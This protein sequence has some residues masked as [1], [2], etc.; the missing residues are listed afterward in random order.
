MKQLLLFIALTS[1]HLFSYSQRN[2]RL[3]T[4][5]AF[6]TFYNEQFAPELYKDEIVAEHKIREIAT[7]T[8]SKKSSHTSNLTFD[9]DGRL[10]QTETKGKKYYSTGTFVY[11]ENGD[12][13]K[14]EHQTSKGTSSVQ[15]SYDSEGRK[16]KT[17][18]NNFKGEETIYTRKYTSR[19]SVAE[20][21]RYY[22]K[23]KFV[24]HTY[25]YDASGNLTFHKVYNEKNQTEPLHVLEYAYWE[26]GSKKTT[27]YR[28]KGK[29]KYVW[30]FD[31]KPEGELLGVKKKDESMI[32]ILE[33]LDVDGNRVVWKREFD[34]KG[35]LIKTKT[36]YGSDSLALSRM[37]YDSDDRLIYEY[38]TAENGNKYRVSYD[39]KGNVS[40]RTD[41][42]YNSDQKLTKVMRSDKKG[43]SQLMLY[44]YEGD[45]ETTEVRVYK[46]STYIKETDYTFY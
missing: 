39:K 42:E 35:N 40:R 26:D 13:A 36:V 34:E 8:Y 23:K 29:V 30:N 2:I 16:V 19:G 11:N 28:K 32:C 46:R 14:T 21:M 17:V 44:S 1:V 4:G 37:I 7:T 20:E 6:K 15:Y 45:L 31:C 27:T 10:V 18:F 12:L 41:W 3:E 25:Q 33:E 38:Q 5:G 22:S 43:T 24:G 9:E